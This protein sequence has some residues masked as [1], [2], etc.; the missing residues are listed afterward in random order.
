MHR[1]TVHEND[2]Q[3]EW[4]KLRIASSPTL[5][6]NPEHSDVIYVVENGLNYFLSLNSSNGWLVSVGTKS[7]CR[8]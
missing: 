8:D 2:G 4:I 6:K 5:R 7:G 3:I 1:A